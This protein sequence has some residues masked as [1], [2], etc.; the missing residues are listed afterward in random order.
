M[1]SPDLLHYAS[2]DITQEAKKLLEP[3]LKPRRFRAGS[4]LWREGDTDGM[5]V[6]IVSGKVKIYRILPD[7]KEI[8]IY[9]FGN[10]VVF[11]FMPF[12][13]G[14]PYPANAQAIV[15]T[16]V[17]VMS[18]ASLLQVIRKTPEVALVL[19]QHLSRRLRE[20]FDQ[21]ERRSSRGTLAKV[22]SALLS[23]LTEEDRQYAGHIITLPL[24]SRDFA[25]LLGIT[26][27]TFSRGITRLVEEEI[28]ERMPGTNKFMIRDIKMLENVARLVAL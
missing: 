9:V 8:T 20:A 1:M 28:V 6:S 11:G 23:L 4:L 2:Y 3:Y 12:L 18:R 21:I 13:D 25:S 22:A 17:L 10:G 27:E 5:L 15:D 26:P 19:I 24:P 7:G 16:D 14:A